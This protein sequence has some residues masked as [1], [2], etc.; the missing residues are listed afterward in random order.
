[1]LKTTAA[2][3]ELLEKLRHGKEEMAV[4]ES[5]IKTLH[6]QTGRFPGT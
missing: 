3:L 6:E 4:L 5:T 1:M 2:N